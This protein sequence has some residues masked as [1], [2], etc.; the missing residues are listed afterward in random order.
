M[1]RYTTRELSKRTWPDYK[2]FFSNGNGWDHCGCT[3]YQGFRAPKN[4]RKWQDKRDWNL[5]VKCSLV[6]RGVAHGILVYDGTEPIGW[7]QFGPK[8]ELPIRADRAGGRFF[9]RGEKRIW[10]ITCFCTSPDHRNEGV[11]AIALRAALS[12]IRTRGGGLVEAYPF[13]RPR[14][15]PKTDERLARF[16][17]WR[18]TTTRLLKTHGR[19]SEEVENHLSKRPD[20]LIE[21]VDGVGPVPAL[22]IHEKWVPHCGTV[23]MFER[24]GF[25]AI[26]V[27]R[28]TNEFS[29]R[30]VVSAL[31]G[32][33]RAQK[34][35][36]HPPRV[37]MQKKI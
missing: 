35:E 5:D 11:T 30:A 4:A 27:L 25:E 6:E 21:H 15:T 37:V 12:A 26:S 9:E 36:S 16:K 18:A 32:S 13:A 24:E 34:D 19:Y 31:A 23:A 14:G 20:P 17:E 22:Y 3:A 7:C 33:K 1:P 2:R 28:I 29:A 8:G 10:R